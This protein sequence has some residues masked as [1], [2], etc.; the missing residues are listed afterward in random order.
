MFT[1]FYGEESVD[2]SLP[3]SGYGYGSINYRLTGGEIVEQPVSVPADGAVIGAFDGL[4]L[5][6]PG[7]M[8]GYGT[9]YLYPCTELGIDL[10]NSRSLSVSVDGEDV[11]LSLDSEEAL[12]EG[13]YVV[14][15]NGAVMD[16]NWEDINATYAFTVDYTVVGVASAAQDSSHA[17]GVFDIMG[18]R[19]ADDMEDAKLPAGIYI[20]NGKKIVVK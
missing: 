12:P 8:E 5:A 6:V 1:A 19:V 10:L 11:V 7:A 14:L 9:A 16:S 18:R 17:G 13:S 20:A 4:T 3:D 2:L 15:T